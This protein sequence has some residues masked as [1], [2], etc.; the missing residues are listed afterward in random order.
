MCFVKR[1]LDEKL[2]R[3]VITVPAIWSDASKQ[4]MR[5][6]ALKVYKEV[7]NVLPISDFFLVLLHLMSYGTAK[8]CLFSALNHI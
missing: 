6:A 5:E 8:N 7:T 4:F 2:I 3:W 1:T